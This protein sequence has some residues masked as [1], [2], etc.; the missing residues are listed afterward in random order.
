MLSWYLLKSI[1]RETI[2]VQN[3]CVETDVM[4]YVCR[5]S[6]LILKYPANDCDFSCA[7][8]PVYAF[9]APDH[10]FWRA[11]IL[12]ITLENNRCGIRS[13]IGTVIVK[14]ILQP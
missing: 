6:Y 9:H 14:T 3:G 2:T 13:K 11:E 10:I 5:G 12:V 1:R 8:M 4:E 7:M